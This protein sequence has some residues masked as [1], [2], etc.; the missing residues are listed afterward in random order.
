MR[1]RSRIRDCLYL[2]WAVPVS[3]LPPPPSRLRYEVHYWEG[4]KFVLLSVLV[5]R[6]E[7]VHARVLPFLRLSFPQLN[8]RLYVLDHE[9]IPSVLFKAVLVPA[10]VVLSARLIG[11]QPARAARFSFEPRLP[12]PGSASED[13]PREWRVEAG[14]TF[15]CTGVPGAAIVHA[16]PRL[17]SWEQTVELLRMRD[18]AY[19]ARGDDLRR[20]ETEQPGAEVCPM[21]VEIHD[22]TLLE[23]CLGIEGWP[24]LHS[25]WLCPELP[26]VFT[27]SRS[28]TLSLP[29]QAPV[30][31]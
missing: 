16:G 9:S 11:G 4:E 18:R 19:V 29:R 3:R 8:V 26:M 1:L 27:L 24:E 28:E 15:H 5:F 6:H 14:G 23:S 12:Q 22:T 21:R 10:W 25:A 2:N 31:G 20:I 7:D 13:R 17:G 30:P